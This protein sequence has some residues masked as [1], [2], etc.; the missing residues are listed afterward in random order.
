MKVAHR[1]V[2]QRLDTFSAEENKHALVIST[3]RQSVSVTVFLPG[4]DVHLWEGSLTELCRL[5]AASLANPKPRLND[6][7]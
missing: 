6:Q 1:T 2:R 4:D 7:P 5:L 3:H